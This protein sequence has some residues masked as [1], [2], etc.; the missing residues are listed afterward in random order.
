[1]TDVPVRRTLNHSICL[2]FP[3]LDLSNTQRLKIA[4]EF[5]D[6]AAERRARCNLGNARIFLGEF[7]E[8]VVDY[9]ETLRLA[10]ELT[11]R[12]MEAQ[13]CYSLGNTYTLLHDFDRALDYHKRHLAIAQELS[14]RV[15]EGRAHWSIS[16]AFASTGRHEQALEHACKH[17]DITK[18]LADE[19][20]Q[21]TALQIVHD[22]KKAIEE[23]SRREPESRPRE[24]AG[25]VGGRVTPKPV[26]KRFSMDNMQ[27]LKLT[28]GLT[29]TNDEAASSNF[30]LNLLSSDQESKS[31]ETKKE[32]IPKTTT[33]VKTAT[34]DD[35]SLLDLVARFQSKRMDDQ[36]CSFDP[37][38]DKENKL[39]SARNSTPVTGSSANSEVKVNNNH[40]NGGKH[41]AVPAVVTRPN[42]PAVLSRSVST[43]SYPLT[44][45]LSSHQTEVDSSDRSG[46]S[47]MNSGSRE[48]NGRD[49]LFDLIAGIQGRRMDEQRAQLPTGLRRANTT[50]SANTSSSGHFFVNST[51][52]DSNFNRI[53][54]PH[55]SDHRVSSRCNFSS[56]RQMSLDTSIHPDDEF[57][58][59]LMRCQGSR[60][61][62]Q[63]SVLPVTEEEPEASH[64]LK[65]T[66]TAA[67]PPVRSGTNTPPSGASTVPDDDFF[68]LILKVQSGRFEDQRS[69]LP[70]TKSGSSMGSV[71]STAS[72]MG[73]TT[74]ESRK[75]SRKSSKSR[76]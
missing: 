5:Q 1:M 15:G 34:R 6:K 63:R 71:S 7:E 57:F 47:S 37:R 41:R 51:D 21:E 44:N 10:Q 27:L 65:R 33:T 75:G 46:A 72:S 49:D 24:A 14:D 30:H 52:R 23:E 74:S 59:M 2:T 64:M 28:P 61:E 20:G 16:N 62:D 43:P 17:L 29:P 36:R 48:S 4:Q 8:A 22:L 38:F 3:I 54:R 35:G 12:V 26:A 58:D 60:L 31:K 9:E 18:E 68:S 42:R 66:S 55:A 19:S 11:D 70:S 50:T 53:H 45:G 73:T 40:A 76:K 25:A 56:S 69:Y 39:P 13:A 32:V 67:G